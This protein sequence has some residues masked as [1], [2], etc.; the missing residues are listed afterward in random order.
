MK[1]KLREPELRFMGLKTW[2]KDQQKRTYIN[3]WFLEKANHIPE[4]FF[5][6][7]NLYIDHNLDFLICGC[8]EEQAAE[9]EE[10]LQAEYKRFC[11]YRRAQQEK[12]KRLKE[13]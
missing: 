5:T 6:V 7:E 1:T 4:W 8:T 2:E 12:L 10:I 3:G 13:S 11:D 9:L